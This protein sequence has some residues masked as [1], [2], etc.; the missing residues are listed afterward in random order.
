MV[1]CGLSLSIF[2]GTPGT[3]ASAS[4]APALEPIPTLAA[5]TTGLPAPATWPVLR[6]ERRLRFL[7]V[8]Q[9]REHAAPYQRIARRCNAALELG[10]Q[11]SEGKQG[12][13]P[14]NTLS[15]T[16]DKW[17][18]ASKDPSAQEV[19]DHATVRLRETLAAGTYDVVFC[20]QLLPELSEYV[21]RGGVWV[22]CG[23]ATPTDDSPLA[24]HWPARPTGK[25]SWHDRGA[26][27]GA[28]PEVAGLP[29][30][31]LAGWQWHGIYEAAA[32]AEALATGQSGAA[33]L[34]RVGRGV[35][36]LVPTGPI[37]KTHDAIQSVH[38]VYDHD[39]IWLRFWDQLL[40]ALPS[41]NDVLSV[42]ADLRSAE[43]E[44]AAGQNCILPGRLLNRGSAAR[45]V[46]V[47]AH[48]V[49]PAG[50]VVYAGEPREVLLAP[51]EDR[52]WNLTLPVAADWP[53]GLY[54]A[55]LTASDPAT[56][57][58]LH[59]ALACMPITGSIQLSLEADKPGFRIGHSATFTIR[60]AAAAPWQG[61]L[62][63]AIHDFR[64]R[65]L[66]AGVLP[67]DLAAETKHIPFSWVFADHGVR[68]DTVWATAVAVQDGWEWARAE[69][70]VYKHER[71]NMRNEYQ[72]STWSNMACH[73]PSVAPQAMRLMAHAGLNALG[74][75]GGGNELF[76]PAE[77]WSWR[78]YDEGVGSNTF[79]PVIESVT[80][81][82]IEAAQRQ[83][84]RIPADLKSGAMVL[85]SVGEEAGFKSGWGR[86]YYWDE[87]V[88]PEKACQAF[89]RFLRERYPS[90]DILNA[91]WGTRYRTWDEIKLTKEFSGKNPTLDADGWTHPHQSPLGTG[92]QG[93]SLAPYTDTM[94]FYHWYYD[95]VVGAALKILREEIN[96]VPLTMASAPSSWI[97]ESPR[98]D[99]RL[100]GGGAWTDS[101]DWSQQAVNGRDPGFGIAWG[102]FDWPVATE[103]VLWGWV[104]TRSGHNNYWVDVPLMFNPDM[105]LTRSTWAIRRWRTRTAHAERL[106]LDA[107]PAP[108]SEAGVLMPTGSYLPRTPSEIANSVKIA[109][110]QGGFGFADADPQTLEKYKLVFAVFRNQ[111]SQA[112]ADAMSTY[113]ERGGTLVFFPRFAG[114]DEYG[115]PQQTVPGFGLAQKWGLTVTGRSDPIPLRYSRA[116]VRADLSGLGADLAG[117]TLESQEFL[118]E[119]VEHNGWIALASYPD[120]TPA[121]LTRRFGKGRLVYLN[122][123]YQSQRYIQWVTST[124]AARQGFYRLIEKL[125]LDAGV[126]RAFR[127]EGDLAQVLH[128][129]A[130]QWTDPTG[131]IGY[132]VTRTHG[133]TIW[134]GGKLHWLGP[135][136]AGYD[137][138]GGDPDAP[139]PVY[140]TEVALQLR[141]GAGRLLAFTTASVKTVKVIAHSAKLTAGDSLAVTVEILDAAGRPVPGQFPLEIRIDGP[142][143]EIAGLRRDLSLASGATVKIGT[144]TN[145]PTGSWT[146]TV[147]DGISRLTGRT[148]VT[149]GAATDTAPVPAFQPWGWPS[150]NWEVERMPAAEF[151]AT[152]RQLAE[153]YRTDHAGQS[154]RA[155]QWLGAHYCL[156]PGT[157]HA[158]LRNLIELDWTRHVEAL[159]QAVAEGTNLILV[160]EDLG[161]DP[162]TGLPAWA[163]DARQLEAVAAA[164]RDATWESLSGDGEVIRASLGR[165]SLVLCRN[166]PDGVSSSW[167][168]AVAWQQDLLRNLAAKPTGDFPVPNAARLARW[169]AGREALKTGLRTA[170]W[171]GGWE[172]EE[173]GA[174]VWR[175]EWTAK[176]DPANGEP[177]PVFVLRLPP[178]GTVREA[179]L[180]LAITGKGSVAMDVGADGGGKIACPSGQATVAFEA[181]TIGGYLAWREQECG[182]SERDLNGWRLVPIRFSADDEAEIVVRRAQVILE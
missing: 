160:G 136:T 5:P 108:P 92:V 170:D 20:K 57:K 153:V 132:V 12:P 138:Y 134:T 164:M 84:L 146:I 60:A 69:C 54:W 99:V 151:V 55:H 42:I 143:G 122:A 131:K 50:K 51:G 167:G 45:T 182:G 173:R 181:E 89:Q 137:V 129:A 1:V 81:E 76:Y 86:T 10:F 21:Q 174:P 40:H 78:M 106:L 179:A 163:C 56:T 168:A 34:R 49:S 152:L 141:P 11:P 156:F 74:Y 41:G 83:R 58:Q 133:Q 17:I 33:F 37:S 113:V 145:D 126:R 118:N 96:P 52:P 61:E 176:V 75:P 48:V 62:R 67:A 150:E 127:M 2:S 39:E 77:R 26:Q 66:G 102:H 8:L 166:T 68:V 121:L 30:E 110:N 154:W 98:T 114:Q 161:L 144:A 3:R 31:R 105:S 18:E 175:N 140:G 70:K 95:R 128:M 117:L 148:G 149:V 109:L 22:V 44:T 73:P 47:S 97:F 101:Q 19:A 15:H 79:S 64:G 94:A 88:A 36:L 9:Q 91:A 147:R 124:D 82:E 4:D 155:K 28:A 116:N 23:T 169:L 59:Q 172:A 35:I 6:H 71:W 7:A 72:W 85:A 112:E 104:I 16:N 123:A 162:A 14:I 53:T 25:N 119:Q 38:R 80:D 130:L 178:V 90:L 142:E 87:P 115:V 46:A 159:R 125:C 13:D 107:V 111:L 27:R 93:V 157:R 135:Q 171:Q 158:L 177:G 43:N 65:Q 100:A 120:G 24:P 32:G 180:D 165:G 29:L 139:A 103:N 63:W